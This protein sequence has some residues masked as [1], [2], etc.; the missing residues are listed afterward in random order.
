METL[1]QNLTYAFRTLRRNPGF[2][3][4]VVLTLGLGIGANAAIFT[5]LDQVL[6]RA[7]PVQ[8]PERLVMLDGPGAFV[9]RTQGHFAF[10]YPMYRDLRD[11]NPVFTGLLAR[12][13]TSV[14][15]T[16]KG[17]AERADSELVS[18]NYFDVLGVRPALGRVLSPD[19][20]RVPGGHPVVVLSHGFWKRRFAADP[21]IL[22][23]AVTV[24]G[25]PMTVVGVAPR[26]FQ[27]TDVASAPDLFVPMMM[28]A[29]VT[30]TWDDLDNRRSRWLQIV[31]RLKPGVGP[32]QAKAA[33]DVVYAPIL[34]DE[35]KLAPANVPS[36][37]REKFLARRLSVLPG[38]RG[39]SDL[40]EQFST[41]LLVLMGMVGL[42]LLI[43][44]ANVA[45]L[46]IARASF[47][48]KEIA[49]RLALGAG[50]RRIVGQLVVES[51]VLAV[52][53][54]LAGLVLAV[55]TSDMLVRALPFEGAVRALSTGPDLRVV[56]FTFAVALLT[57]LVFGL[58]PAWQSSRPALTSTLKNEST[59]VTAGHPRARL[60]KGLVVAQ[61]AFSLL[62]L[63][64]A[65]LFSRSLSNLRSLDPGFQADRVLT[66][67]IDASLNGYSQERIRTLVAQ[68]QERLGSLPGVK[69]AGLAEN[70]MVTG[71]AWSSTIKIPG[72][73]P[74]EGE[75]M[76]PNVN[77]VGPGF[78]STLGMPLVAGREFT[79]RDSAEAPKVAVINETMA[80]KHFPG[81]IPLGER[82][83]FAGEEQ[84]PVEIVGVVKDAKDVTLRDESARYVYTPYAQGF[85]LGYATFFVKTGAD[86]PSAAE[87]TRAA[88]RQI[89]PALPVFALKTLRVQVEESLFAER[90][91]ALLSACFGVLAT[92]LAAVGLYGVMAYTVGQRTREFGIR[93]ALGAERQ[94][95][96]W[97]VLREVALLGALGIALGLPAA[98]GLARVV[99]SQ[100]YGL[101]PS[102][103]VT[104]AT[105]VV[106]IAAAALFAGFVPA[107]RATR[108]EPMVALRYE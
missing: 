57:G 66:F 14:T 97:L 73:T 80:R 4:V 21:S 69:Q 102:D 26:G 34:E 28:K 94:R 9:G 74:Q 70:G 90:A 10:S 6:L 27:G 95:I 100:L 63:I 39:Q 105:S 65:G 19:D 82:F 56:G 2:A 87:A 23:Q 37:F 108:V 50:R 13:S 62:L 89:D 35:V 30:P 83:F 91:V 8:E 24:N 86:A 107:R 52:L 77:R 58:L 15:L 18:G 104:L 101:S 22:N 88:V 25:H 20:D 68:I 42:V 41:P 92:L 99:Q 5:V 46:L 103:P 29:Q 1:R 12:Y 93:V 85:E 33:L 61:V 60:R 78:F 48:Q 53:G 59:T 7:L 76:N 96:L 64:G 106:V 31:G 49:V 16:Y 36:G 11:R 81:R 43:A 40:R 55:W 71:A 72:Y 3:A 98:W 79:E 38:L 17:Q 67:A 84:D 54:G 75:N 47:R 44:C 32:E 45:N 51:L